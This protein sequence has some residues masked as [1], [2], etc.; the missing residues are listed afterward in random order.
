MDAIITYLLDEA[1]KRTGKEAEILRKAAGLIGSEMAFV[2]V[3]VSSGTP[4]SELSKTELVA[5]ARELGVKGYSKM[6]KVELVKAVQSRLDATAPTVKL[7]DLHI[8]AIELGVPKW[9][10]L[11]DAQIAAAVAHRENV[12]PEP[13]GRTEQEEQR[14]QA[15]SKMTKKEPLGIAGGRVTGAYSMNKTE[16][17]QGIL[18]TE[19][20]A[21]AHRAS[22]PG[23]SEWTRERLEPLTIFDLR[24]LSGPYLGPMSGDK[25]VLID[26]LVDKRKRLR[27]RQSECEGSVERNGER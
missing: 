21:A 2:R 18:D 10:E 19:R 26:W 5:K 1:K 20:K 23:P 6:T 13:A 24:G 9:D 27:T 22:L 25:E 14:F 16:L 17:V 15:L 3:S 4:T 8:R 7:S 11:E 12:N